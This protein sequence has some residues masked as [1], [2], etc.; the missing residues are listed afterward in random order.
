MRE[1]NGTPRHLMQQA[2]IADS[3]TN[4]QTALGL[5]PGSANTKMGVGLTVEEALTEAHAE[6][7]T[8]R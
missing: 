2:E 5:T 7:T 3:L 4:A 6:T 8:A 1:R